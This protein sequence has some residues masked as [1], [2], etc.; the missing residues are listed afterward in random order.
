LK[1]IAKESAGQRELSDPQVQNS[2]RETLR[3]R[4]EQLLRVA[5]LSVA[6]DESHVV[7]YLARQVLESA[8]KLPAAESPK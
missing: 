3:N 7:N 1:L 4:K 8:G 5:Y 2:I 6:R